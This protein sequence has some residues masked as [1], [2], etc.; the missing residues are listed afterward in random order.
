M[1]FMVGSPGFA[2]PRQKNSPLDYFYLRFG[3]LQTSS[4]LGNFL[5]ESIVYI[6]KKHS[7]NCVKFGGQGWIRTIVRSRGQI[8]S[9]VPL[10]TRPPTHCGAPSRIRTLDLPVMSRL[11]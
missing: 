1:L 9:L 3:W 8:Y 5:F 11:L 6:Q 10:T 2:E 7:K 4:K